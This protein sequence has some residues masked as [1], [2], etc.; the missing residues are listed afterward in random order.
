[1]SNIK[2]EYVGKKASNKHNLESSWWHANEQELPKSVAAVVNT[3]DASQTSRSIMNEKYSRLYS[4]L[5]L[6]GFLTGQMNSDSFIN[7]KVTFNVIKSCID[8]AKSKIA[9]NKPK[10]QF[11]TEDGDYALKQRAENLTKYVE[12]VF[13]DADVYSHAQTIFTHGCVFGTGVMKVFVENEKICVEPVF[14]QELKIDDMDA[15]YGKPR[16]MHQVKYVSREVLL[17]QYPEHHD[18]IM[19]LSGKDMI[20]AG[21]TYNADMVKVIESWHLR[22]GKDAKDGKRCITVESAV[23]FS[24]EY[25]KDYFPFVFFRWSDRIAGFFGQGLAEELIGIQIEINKILKNIQKAMHLIAVPRI[26]VDQSSKISTSTIQNEIGSIFKYA[27]NPPSFFTPT[28][29]NAETYNHLKWLIQSAYE[30]SG[31]SQLSATGK[32][33]AGLDAAVALREYQDIETERFMITAQKYEKVFMQL[34]EMIVD[35]SRDMYEANPKLEMK[36]QT[37]KF[38][39][40]IKWKDVNLEDSQFVMK[41]FPV[42]LLPST[43]AGRLQKVQELIQSG[44]IDKDQG[45]ALLEFP[46]LDS[47][48]NL[49]MSA[50][51]LAEKQL[52]EITENGKYVGPEPQQ[53]LD[54]SI[55]LAQQSFL[56][57]KIDNLGEDKLELLLRYIDDAERLKSQ[58]VPQQEQMPVEEAPAPEMN[59]V[60]VAPVQV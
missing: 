16:Q 56:R 4:N 59:E 19:G 57:G 46:D 52:Y 13:Y 39:K 32:K 47:V 7:N 55:Q 23:L 9:K 48:Q 25:A 5:E 12:G 38:I 34:T 58:A 22:S 45:L 18:A 33:P 26:A 54:L 17:N 1:M 20:R 40:T 29:M 21:T 42:S 35:M 49:Q 28:A 31:I 6:R 10:I 11:L 36:V 37:S 53:N 15:A 60:P 44:F 24:E 41:M 27:G 51:K 8:T 30:V 14:I 43:P 2:T 3:I 50:L